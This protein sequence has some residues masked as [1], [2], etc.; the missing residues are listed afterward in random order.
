MLRLDTLN[1]LRAA[2]RERAPLVH[3]L[4]S[5]T[6]ANFTANA[7]LALGAAP[8]MVESIDEVADFA[9]AADALVINIGS[10]TPERARTMRRAIAAATGA[11]TPWVLDPVAAGA[12]AARTALALEFCALGPAA[13]RGNASEIRSLAGLPGGGRGVDTAAS[14]DTAIEAARALATRTGAVVAVTGAT[15][16]VTDG[17]TLVSVP[18]GHPMMTRVTGMGC[19]ASAIV[20]ACLAVEPDRVAAA[21]HALA[22]CGIAGERAARTAPGPGS[23]AVA[24]LD[25][26]SQDEP[27]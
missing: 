24:W 15:D 27:G 26:L 22:L 3:N 20:A 23:L 6:V 19:A 7:L 8:A 2:L 18:H 1:R 9:A 16:H 21:S 17:T 5:P 4:T 12:I 10:V 11:G 14:S 13:I 25:L